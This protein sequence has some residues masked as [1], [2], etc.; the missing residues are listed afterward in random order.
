MGC[1]GLA[2]SILWCK[3]PKLKSHLTF[4]VDSFKP[5]SLRG[6][7]CLAEEPC[8]ALDKLNL[9]S[10][11]KEA[12][13]KRSTSKWVPMDLSMRGSSILATFPVGF[14]IDFL[15]KSAGKIKNEDHRIVGAVVSANGL[16]TAQTAIM[17]LRGHY[18]GITLFS[19]TIVF[20]NSCW[21]NGC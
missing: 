20:L 10:V 19:S 17:W 11:L 15:E 21:V 14:P 3:K 5:A 7:G 6:K 13:W 2:P 9:I 1:F 18:N 4:A 12:D 16:P 8:P